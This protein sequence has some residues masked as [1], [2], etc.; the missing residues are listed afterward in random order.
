MKDSA[1]AKMSHGLTHGG[2]RMRDSRS[3]RALRA[4][5]ISMVTRTERETVMGRR[6]A[7]SASN[8]LLSAQSKPFFIPHDASH[9]SN[10]RSCE[11][12]T[13]GPPENSSSHQT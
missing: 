5:N 10:E 11:K 12:D 7:P 2:V 13:W 9:F 6:P 1:I 3:E 4:L 8:G